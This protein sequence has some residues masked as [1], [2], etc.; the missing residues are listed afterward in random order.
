MPKDISLGGYT[1]QKF[2]QS[3]GLQ[4]NTFLLL[5]ATHYSEPKWY[6]L[7]FLLVYIFTLGWQGFLMCF[8]ISLGCLFHLERSWSKG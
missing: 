1:L 3:P 8:H 5:I 4:E 6:C 2:W 7:S